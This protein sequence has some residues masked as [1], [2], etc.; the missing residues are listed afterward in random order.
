MSRARHKTWGQRVVD[1][2][3]TGP[4]VSTGGQDTRAKEVQDAGVTDPCSIYQ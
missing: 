1:A 2:R 4:P 3:A